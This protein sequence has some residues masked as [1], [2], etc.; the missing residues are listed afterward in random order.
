MPR[1]HDF[2][3]YA[4]EWEKMSLAVAT[5]KERAMLILIAQ[6]WIRLANQMDRLAEEINRRA[7]KVQAN[8]SPA[9]EST[10]MD[11]ASAL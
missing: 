8:A 11:R 9:C 7:S 2:R 1:A 3:R 4:A 6:T 10:Q 5:A